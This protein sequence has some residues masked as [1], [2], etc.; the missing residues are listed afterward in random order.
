MAG[1]NDTYNVRTSTSPSFGL[2]A[3]SSRSAKCVGL[4]IPTGRSISFH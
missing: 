1:S 3:G 2:G 4:T